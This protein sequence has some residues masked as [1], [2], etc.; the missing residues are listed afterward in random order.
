MG[1]VEG[2]NVGSDKFK[3]HGWSWPES[4][5]G[6]L[7]AILVVSKEG[8]RIRDA[9]DRKSEKDFPPAFVRRCDP[10]PTPDFFITFVLLYNLTRS[11]HFDPLSP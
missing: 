2:I 1:S 7:S 11:R 9:G 4:V 6:G 8:G 3:K 5:G 10:P